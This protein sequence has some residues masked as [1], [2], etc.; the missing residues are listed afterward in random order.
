MFIK[1]GHQ[2][3]RAYE[4]GNTLKSFDKAIE[5]G[6]DVIEFDVRQTRDKKIIVFHDEKVNRLTKARGLVRDFTLKEIKNLRVQGELIPTLQEALDFI[7]KKVKGIAIELKEVGVEKKVIEEIERRGLQH[8]VII[9]SFLEEALRNI[10]KI[11]REIETGLVYIFLMNPIGH[12][13]DIGAKYLLPMYRFISVRTIEEAHKEGL[14]VIVWT[15]NGR[16]EMLKCLK[17]GVDGIA[18][19]K[20]DILSILEI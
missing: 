12:A 4:P 1:V 9:I 8:R 20:P 7:D 16:K 10:R 14:K 6:V 15:V 13:L 3:A 17:K 2:G 11:N 19:D 18:T 5:L